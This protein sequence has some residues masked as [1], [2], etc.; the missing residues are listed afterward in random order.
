MKKSFKERME[1]FKGSKFAGIAKEAIGTV[2]LPLLSNVPGAGTVINVA[3][4]VVG[5]SKSKNLVDIVETAKADNITPKGEAGRIKV[6]YSVIIAAIFAS[7]I[8]NGIAK[9]VWGIEEFI[10]ISMLFSLI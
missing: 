6:G 8:V 3:R 7:F 1:N 10:P 2:A 9:A 4:A 5:K